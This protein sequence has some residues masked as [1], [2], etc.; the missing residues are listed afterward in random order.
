[1]GP[2]LKSVILITP[3]SLFIL[4]YE[5]M[6]VTALP[7]PA[8][9]VTA[10][11]A[12]VMLIIAAVLPFGAAVI[13]GHVAGKATAARRRKI[14]SVSL[15]LYFVA[16]IIVALILI[17]GDSANPGGATAAERLAWSLKLGLAG[18][19]MIGVVSIPVILLYTIILE[20]WTRE[21]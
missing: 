9:N 5:W 14:F 10:A 17:F 1:M 16:A 3:L 19:L 20:K 4:A 6:T 13:T 12:A 8:G 7:A 21:K 15:A 2:I 18:A 11:Q